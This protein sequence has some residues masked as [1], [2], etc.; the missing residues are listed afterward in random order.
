MAYNE[1]GINIIMD[2]VYNHV[3]GL[4]KSN[5]DVLMPGYY[6]RYSNGAP[7][8]GS[9]CGNETASENYMFRKFMIDSTEF[10]AE[11]YKLGGYRFDLMGVHDIETMNQLTENLH[12]NV[13]ESIVVYGEPWAGGTTAIPSGSTAAT[14]ANM[15][16]YEGYGCFND[17]MRDALIKGG[18]SGVTETGWITNDASVNVSDISNIKAGLTGLVLVG[19]SKLE[20]EK[21]INYVT[22]HDNY[23]LYDRIRAAGITDEV[24]I[25]KMAMLANSLVFTSQGVSF[26]LAGEEFLRTKGGNENS[27]NASYKV[28]ELDYSLKVKNYDMF[29]NYQKLIALKQ[30]ANL[31]SKSNED[32]KAIT[33]NINDNGSMIYYD[34]VDQE[35]GL[36]YRIIHCNGVSAGNKTIDLDGYN[37]YLDTLGV[38]NLQLTATTVISN[39]Q[40]IVAYKSIN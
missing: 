11:E 16:Q 9:G 4:E 19:N 21:C 5:F 22:C 15:N 20:A 26:M 1:A 37:L 10:W 34:L 17:K 8:N 14:Q 7:S 35:A 12:T 36:S 29:T 23:T 3:N 39:Y 40:T 13:N 6:F 27:Y 28:N 32:C 33:I 31:F 38:E 18:L 25:K 24:T 30:N 2:V